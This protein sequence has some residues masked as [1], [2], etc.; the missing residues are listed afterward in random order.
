V[1]E[2][3]GIGG[4][5]GG[6]GAEAEE[7]VVDIVGFPTGAVVFAG[8]SFLGEEPVGPAGV[9]VHAG[10]GAATV[11]KPEQER[12]GEHVAGPY[13]YA[14]HEELE[15]GDLARAAE[16]EVDNGAE[17]DGVAYAADDAEGECNDFLYADPARVAGEDADDYQGYDLYK[18][19]NIQDP[20]R[21]YANT[22]WQDY[23]HGEDKKNGEDDGP[24]PLAVGYGGRACHDAWGLVF[25]WL[26][27]T[28]Y[29]DEK[30]T[31]WFG[32]A[33]HDRLTMGFFRR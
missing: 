32:G 2:G 21:Q 19:D 22:V 14:G 33:H 23:E 6:G 9:V 8:G 20:Y 16:H 26:G 12:K 13:A 17:V 7:E 29:G 1:G 24:A 11:D 31:P 30:I 25:R 28:V 10:I 5:E 18:Y 15:A 27:V 4:A 3:Q